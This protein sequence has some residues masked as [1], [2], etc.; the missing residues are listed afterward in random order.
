MCLQT[1][2]NDLVLSIGRH[3]N[4]SWGIASASAIGR[5]APPSNTVR[6]SRRIDGDVRHLAPS[7]PPIRIPIAKTP[8]PDR[9]YIFLTSSTARLPAHSLRMDYPCLFYTSDAANE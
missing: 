4:F 8:R 5:C 3:P 1:S 2:P 6:I 9:L 7:G